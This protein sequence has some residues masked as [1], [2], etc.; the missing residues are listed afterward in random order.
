MVRYKYFTECFIV[1]GCV[2]QT[3][4]FSDSTAP[5]WFSTCCLSICKAI[6]YSH[7]CEIVYDCLCC[8]LQKYLEDMQLHMPPSHRAFLAQ[9]R[10][11]HSV[12]DTVL[13]MT[14][15]QQ[16]QSR[17][18]VLSGGS[19][20]SVQ[21]TTTGGNA[22][23]LETYN[24]A[25]H[26]LE[27]FRAQHRGFANSYIAQWSKKEVGTGGSDFMPALTGYKDATAAHV[28]SGKAKGGCP[29]HSG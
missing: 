12:R 26:E 7:C 28:L 29:L 27:K 10:A 18:S 6:T 1:S 20:S 22:S 8:R 19:S 25:I 4:A 11:G 23:L 9:L 16:Q 5:A 17:D 13:S 24:A 15:Q 3:V 21:R 14:Q 2:L